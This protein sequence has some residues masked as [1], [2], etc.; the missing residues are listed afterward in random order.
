MEITE[1]ETIFFTESAKLTPHLMLSLDF[2]LLFNPS[3]IEKDNC[4]V[5]FKKLQFSPSQ[6]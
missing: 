3:S 1:T 6:Q 4:S 2:N 5:L